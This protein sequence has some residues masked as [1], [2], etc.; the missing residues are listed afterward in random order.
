MA[1]SSHFYKSGRGCC[2]GGNWSAMN[3]AAMVVGFVFFWPVGLLILYWNISGR[4]IKDL[5]GAIQEKWSS[6]FGNP[7]KNTKQHG[8]TISE[9]SVFEEFQQTQYDRIKEI[10][11]EIKNR[12]HS[13]KEFRS[14]AKRRAE[15]REFQDFMASNP[16]RDDD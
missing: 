3:I 5:P 14:N 7:L 16:S 2:M 8:S 15:E 13:F 6:M 4:D 1:S 10:K 12:A 9:N 11:E